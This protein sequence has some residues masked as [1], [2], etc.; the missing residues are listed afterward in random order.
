VWRDKLLR[1]RRVD[2]VLV[3][4]ELH[5]QFPLKGYGGIE[6]SVENIASALHRMG[7]PF[8]VV[9]PGR[10]TR[11]EYPFDVLETQLASNGRHGHAN[12][13]VEEALDLMKNRK[14]LTGAALPTVD[15]WHTALKSAPD[16]PGGARERPLVIWGQSD[17]SQSFADLSVVT[18]T[19]HHDGGGPVGHLS[20]G[21]WDR[22]IK[23]V[24]HRFLSHDQRNQWVLP[25]DEKNLKR[26]RVIPHGL[27]PEDYMLCEDGGYFLWVAGLDWGWEEKGLHI[28]TA[29]A[30]MR[31]ELQFVA[32]GVA[33]RRPDLEER[34]RILS[35][36]L[37]NFDFR[38]QLKRGV[39]HR[40]VFC[41]ATAFFM[42]TQPSI[43]ASLPPPPPPPPPKAI[44]RPQVAYS[45]LPL[46]GESFGMTV[47]ESLS[48]GVPVIAST[49]G[50]V[51]EIL[52]VE[53]RHGFSNQGAACNELYEYEAALNKCVVCV[54]AFHP[55]PAPFHPPPP[56]SLVSRSPGPLCAPWHAP[57]VSKRTRESTTSRT[58]SIPY[59]SFR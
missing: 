40:K 52:D 26:T 57:S 5:Q 50:A 3:G 22:H 53:G 1:R 18:I 30:R 46:P 31:P 20:G 39:T 24:G 12:T 43:G 47:I 11:P 14:D 21:R 8:W 7:I 28:F 16:G 49:A 23:H 35:Y 25:D 38:G 44:L 54:P 9:T 2:L 33:Y 56:L 29:L 48:K 55:P 41:E 37:P 51:P 10:S 36:E 58:W 45:P 19:S 59:C 13:F 17:W 27:P 15:R 34:L 42:P 6:T 32:Y 4:N